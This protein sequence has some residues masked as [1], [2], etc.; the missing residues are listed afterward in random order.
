MVF[1]MQ[2]N[3][4]IKSVTNMVMKSN[5]CALLP[6][7]SWNSLLLEAFHLDLV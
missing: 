1:M 3:F 5:P 2:K 6:V 7:L 4:V